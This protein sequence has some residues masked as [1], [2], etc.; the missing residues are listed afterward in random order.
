MQWF[1]TML[2]RTD[3][4]RRA[5]ATLPRDFAGL[6][7]LISVKS[8]IRGLFKKDRP[9]HEIFLNQVKQHPNKVAIIEIESGRQ[10][11]Y[12]ELNALA[13]QYANLYVH[14]L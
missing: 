1:C 2:L 14:L 9:I 6:K 5:L 4:G 7:L 13:N 8:T 3:F 10:L 12:Q 11:T